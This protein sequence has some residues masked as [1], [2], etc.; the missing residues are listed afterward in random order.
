MTAPDGLAA[1]VFDAF[2][3]DQAQAT[4]LAFPGAFSATSP[5]PPVADNTDA[6]A[7]LLPAPLAQALA[8]LAEERGVAVQAL[9]DAARLL[10]GGDGP[11]TAGAAAELI[12]AAAGRG[13]QRLVPAADIEKRETRIEMLEYRNKALTGALERVS[14]QPLDGG[15]RE[16][17]DAAQIFGFAN[18]WCFD[19]DRVTRRFRELAPVY[20]PDTGV[21][22]DRE[23]MAQ[24]IEAR[25]LLIR[26]VR[27]AYPSGGWVG[28]RRG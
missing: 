19:E 14:F 7:A 17:R 9:L 1:E 13:P 20:H 27:T 25:N 15:V 12:L 21:V 6:P 2:D 11:Q 4:V 23:R 3:A 16:V 5:P 28:K 8:R 10:I 26:H 22:A 24:L 18:E